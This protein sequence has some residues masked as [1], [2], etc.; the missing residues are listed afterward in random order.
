MVVRNGRRLLVLACF[1]C[2]EGRVHNVAIRPEV[3]VVVIVVTAIL[4]VTAVLAFPLRRG[5][6]R[7][8][9]TTAVGS[10][11]GATATRFPT[12]ARFGFGVVV[13][14]ATTIATSALVDVVVIVGSVA[15]GPMRDLHHNG[16][17][18]VLVVVHR[19]TALFRALVVLLLRLLLVVV[20]AKTWCGGVVVV[21]S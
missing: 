19:S 4:I 7:F 9:A 3:F 16:R 1:L 6:F 11:H 5:A 14:T 8:A 12:R 15:H 10:A 20:L 18:V 17:R 13:A 21:W 2:A